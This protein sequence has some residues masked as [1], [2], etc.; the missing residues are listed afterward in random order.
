MTT[1]IQI[2]EE[3]QQR[4]FQIINKIEKELGRRVSYNEAIK[5]LLDLQELKINR[6]EFIKDIEKFF[7]I[8]KPGEGKKYLKEMRDL[9]NDRDKRINR[10]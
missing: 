3:I 7:G 10:G 1:T 5:Y 4:L 8:L 2:T 6:K 9:E